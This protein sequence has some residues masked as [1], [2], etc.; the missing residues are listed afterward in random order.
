M[1]IKKAIVTGGAG[2]IGSHIVE[3]LLSVGWHVKVIDNESAETHDNFFWNQDAENYKEDVCDYKSIRPLFDG[4][5]VVFHLAAESRIQPTLNNPILAAEVNT[6]GTCTV[7]QCAKEAGV[8]RVVYSS[9]SASYGLKNKT[10][11]VES[12]PNDCLNPYSVSKAAGEEL[13]KMYTNLFGLETVVLRYFNI[14]GERQPLV[15]PY[16]P[17]IGLFLKQKKEGK[18]MTIVGDGLQRRDFTYVKDVVDA[19]FLAAQSN[20]ASGEVINIGT[21]V[22]YSVLGIAKKIGGDYIFIE[23]RKGEARETL[24]DNSKAKKL[25]LWEPKT[26]LKKWI[27]KQ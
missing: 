20:Q 3:H 13:C 4:V 6:V 25:L 17:V 8:K 9:T 19:N 12:M 5:D 23:N 27:K 11:N 22:N 24:A 10:P 2:F 16:A 21:G 15:G 18:P 7:L 26:K 14:Y 1:A